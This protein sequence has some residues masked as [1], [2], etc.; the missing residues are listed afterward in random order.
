[1]QQIYTSKDIENYGLEVDHSA[2][3]FSSISKQNILN[4]GTVKAHVV[5]TISTQ[6]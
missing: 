5:Y 1:M 6:V 4:E 2:Q 3:L